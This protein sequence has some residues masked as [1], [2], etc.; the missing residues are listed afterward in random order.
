MKLID[1]SNHRKSNDDSYDLY[2]LLTDLDIKK[3]IKIVFPKDTY[4]INSD[5]CFE[6]PLCISNHGFNGYKRIAVLLEDMEN[7]EL[8]FNGSTL[9]AHDVISICAIINSK[10]ITVKNLTVENPTTGFLQTRVIAHGD[11]Y[12]DVETMLGGGQ[13]HIRRDG[14][15]AYKYKETSLDIL[16]AKEFIPETGEIEP[17]TTDLPFEKPFSLLHIEDIGENKLRINGVK[18]YPPIGNIIIFYNTRRLSCGFFCEGSSDLRIEN[19]TVHSCVGMGLLAQVCHNIH[20]DNFSTKR[21]GEQYYTANVDAT[22]FV[23][24]T[25]LVTVENCLFENQFD[26]ALNIHGMYTK[27]EKAHE[28]ELFVREV[29]Y[30]ATGIKIY[31]PGDKIQAL[32]FLSL[33]PYTEK[34]IDKVEYINQDIVRLTLCESAEDIKEGDSIENISH[35]ADLVFRNNTVRNN[36]A[37]GMLIATRGKTLVENNYFHASGAAIFFEANGDFW[38]ES[39][40]TLDVTVRN[41]KFDRCC[42][43]RLGLPTIRCVPRKGIE[44]EKYFHKNISVVDNTFNVL[45]ENVVEF[46]NVENITFTGNKVTCVGDFD[47]RITVKH[48]KNANIN[49]EI[50]IDRLED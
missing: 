16:C 2:R 11:R 40:G 32:S 6:R 31:K 9:I 28:N 26:D 15:L 8:D 12:V 19:V 46:D 43:S 10:K 42:Y 47:A 39:G 29:H 45:N 50:K 14:E 25:G 37:R 18:R 21:H 20:L 5:Y 4:D 24:C 22:H 33:I 27:V 44:K 17:D 49:T 41:N 36:R 34:T 35:A 7:V 48:V 30:Q 1:F 3:D 38:Y 23:N 13:F